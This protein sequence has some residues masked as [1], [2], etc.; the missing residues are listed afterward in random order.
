MMK[1]IFK[2]S[3]EVEPFL[4]HFTDNDGNVILKS[5]NYKA[6]KSALNGIASV[7]KHA[8]SEKRYE[9]KE[10]EEN[11]FYFNLKSTNGQIVGT[12][13]IFESKIDRQVAMT[14]LGG[15]AASA[16]VE[17]QTGAA[18]SKKASKAQQQTVKKSVEENSEEERLQ[19]VASEVKKKPKAVPKPKAPI[20]PTPV[21]SDKPITEK[22]EKS[23]IEK[24]TGVIRG[25]AGYMGK[26]AGF[27]I[28]MGTKPMTIFMGSIK[29]MYKKISKKQSR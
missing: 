19:K 1:V 5:E 15:D 26:A 2:K 21:K 12:S 4:F 7:K 22:R 13:P 3:D 6:K 20:A 29:D 18:L 16:E 24:K 8:A 14:M 27:G 9:L 25:F 23:S 11:K 10:A 28:T 17:D